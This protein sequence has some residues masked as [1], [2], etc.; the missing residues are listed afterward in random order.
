MT[1]CTDDPLSDRNAADMAEDSKEPKREASD[2][3]PQQESEHQDSKDQPSK[4]EGE[5]ET[6]LFK[7]PMF[8]I[9]GGGVAAVVL[10]GGFLWWLD[11]RQYEDTDDAFVDAHIVRLAAQTT[12][13]LTAVYAADNRHVRKGDL[14]ATI[15][16]ETPAATF[17]EAK[18]NV[19]QADAAIAQAQAKVLSAIAAQKQARA[20]ALGPAANAAKAQA[21]Y[22][23]YLDLQTRDRMAVAPTQVDAARAQ[24]E[25]SAAQAL[26]ARRQIE[27]AAANVL[28]ARKEVQSAQA[29]RQAAVARQQQANVTVS[30]TT[31]RAPIDGQVVNRSVNVGSYVAPGQQ[32]LA[33]VPDDLWVTANFKETQLDHMRPGQPV[34]IRIDAYPGVDFPGHIDS[35]Q[36]GAGQAFAV[37][38]PQNATG[39][40]VKVV[41][42]VPVRIL[43]NN[44]PNP[45]YV[46]GPGMSVVPRVTVR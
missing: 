30:Y 19:S 26:A 27:S 35:I 33:I 8:W 3:N 6:P 21:D 7:R 5:Q 40:Y 36:R 25:A 42:R 17:Q 18:S 28:A 11:A 43:F 15:E 34:R 31:I 29:N 14:L 2:D 13:R 1:P 12:G 45:A 39:N 23:R 16:P 24:A 41:Q 22:R 4:D 38:P 46:I 44:R 32:M 37:L 9:V 20:D 10:I